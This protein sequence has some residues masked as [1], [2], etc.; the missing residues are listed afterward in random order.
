MSPSL[1]RR[2]I[3][4]FPP[5]PI[6]PPEIIGPGGIRAPNSGLDPNTKSFIAAGAAG[7]L[8]AGLNRFAKQPFGRTFA[9]ANTLFQGGAKAQDFFSRPTT[10]NYSSTFSPTGD[11]REIIR[12]SGFGGT[13]DSLFGVEPELDPDNP[14]TKNPWFAMGPTYTPN[15]KDKGFSGY[16]PVNWMSQLGQEFAWS[17][18][19]GKEKDQ[20]VNP[21]F[22]F[23]QVVNAADYLGDT[24]AGALTLPKRVYDIIPRVYNSPSSIPRKFGEFFT[25]QTE[26]QVGDKT[27]KIEG[28]GLIYEAL[29]TLTPSWNLGESIYGFANNML[30]ADRLIV[31]QNGQSVGVSQRE[32][33]LRY[34][35]LDFTPEKR[36]EAI[37]Q[38]KGT[39]KWPANI[40]EPNVVESGLAYVHSAA[41]NR[42]RTFHALPLGEQL[43]A[44]I[45]LPMGLES[46]TDLAVVKKALGNNYF[47]TFDFMQDLSN[48][49]KARRGEL[50]L[51]NTAVMTLTNNM[52]P[53]ARP[54][55][56][57]AAAS[58]GEIFEPVSWW[59]KARRKVGLLGLQ[60]KT[61]AHEWVRAANGAMHELFTFVTPENTPQIMRAIIDY[62]DAIAEDVLTPVQARARTYLNSIG[63]QAKPFDEATRKFLGLPVDAVEDF[64]HSTSTTAARKLILDL[65]AMGRNKAGE[66]L[67]LMEASKI[68]IV[69]AGVAPT[70]ESYEASARAQ[71]A[72]VKMVTEA[73]Q[74]SL[75]KLLGVEKP[76]LLQ[77]INDAMGFFASRFHFA[78]IG[79]GV[80]NLEQELFK[81]LGYS[82]E[83]LSTSGK[84]IMKFGRVIAGAAT[85]FDSDPK[86][87]RAF[88][89]GYEGTLK[90]GPDASFWQKISNHGIAFMS[91]T[92]AYAREKYIQSSL[93]KVMGGYLDGFS[94]FGGATKPVMPAGLNPALWQKLLEAKRGFYTADDIRSFMAAYEGGGESIWTNGRIRKFI[95]A[96]LINENLPDALHPMLLDIFKKTQNDIGPEKM[97]GLLNELLSEINSKANAILST[98]HKLDA[99]AAGNGVPVNLNQ[100]LETALPKVPADIIAGVTLGKV[101]AA[102]LHVLRN[103]NSPA[104]VAILE[105]MDRNGIDADQF[106]RIGL[107][108][109]EKISKYN[110]AK[111][112]NPKSKPQLLWESMF[113]PLDVP[114]SLVVEFRELYE[115]T[116][117][118]RDQALDMVRQI[119]DAHE[120]L[121]NDNI[122][123]PN[124]FV[125]FTKIFLVDLMQP[126]HPTISLAEFLITRTG[127]MS[128]LKGLGDDLS[129][130]PVSQLT[131]NNNMLLPYLTDISKKFGT[132]VGEFTSAHVGNLKLEG[133]ARQEVYRQMAE[134]TRDVNYQLVKVQEEI[135][136]S[137][138]ADIVS[139][140]TKGLA[141]Q[142]F[143]T[144]A[145]PVSAPRAV[146]S[147]ASAI[148]PF[149]PIPPT[150]A[151]LAFH[152]SKSANL[153][154]FSTNVLG[155]STR[156]TPY[157]HGFYFALNEKDA[158][159]RAK[160]FAI[161]VGLTYKSPLAIDSTAAN[162][163]EIL[164]GIFGYPDASFEEFVR[165]TDPDDFLQIMKAKGYD[166]V[167][168]YS[169]NTLK[170][171]VVL[172]PNQIHKSFDEARQIAGP[173]PAVVAAP[174]VAPAVASVP[175]PNPA[176]AVASTA[177]TLPPIGSLSDVI[178]EPDKTGMLLPIEQEAKQIAMASGMIRKLR[179]ELSDLWRVNDA[180]PNATPTESEAA[181]KLQQLMITQLGKM[182]AVAEYVADDFA[183]FH[184]FDYS[185]KFNFDRYAETLWGYPF[186]WLRTYS[187]YPRQLLM[188]PNNLNH[189]WQLHSRVKEYNE[190]RGMPQNMLNTLPVPVP[191]SLRDFFRTDAMEINF[192]GAISP[193]DRMLSGRVPDPYR[194]RTALGETYN[195]VFS[196]ISPA[197]IIPLALGTAY[198]F[199]AETAKDPEMMRQ[200]ETFF[201]SMG[202]WTG[203]LRDV[204]GAAEAMTGIKT[205]VSGG[206]SV[207]PAILGLEVAFGNLHPAIKV[208]LGAGA[209]AQF[210]SQYTLTKDGWVNTGTPYDRNKVSNVLYN[211]PAGS[212]VNGITVTEELLVDAA[213]VAQDPDKYSRMPEFERATQVWKWA[214][215]ETRKSSS[216]LAV[217]SM[218]GG[219]GMRGFGKAEKEQQVMVEEQTQLF[220]AMKNPAISDQ[221]IKSMWEDYSYKHPRSDIRTLFHRYGNQAFQVYAF[222][223][224]GRAM[225]FKKGEILNSAGIP[226]EL[227]SKFYDGLRTQGVGFMTST[228]EAAF[229]NGIIRAGMLLNFPDMASAEEI[230]AV[231]KLKPKYDAEL[232]MAYPKMDPLRDVLYGLPYEQ[233]DQ[234]LDEH[235]EL[236]SYLDAANSLMMD[237]KYRDTLAP[238]YLSMKEVEDLVVN[239]YMAKDPHRAV[240]LRAYLS[241]YKTFEDNKNLN[242]KKAYMEYFDLWDF[243]KGY[244]ALK[245]N[246]ESE[247]YNL[248]ADI[249]LPKLPTM[250]TG[251]DAYSDSMAVETMANTLNELALTGQKQ[252]DVKDA[253]LRA[254]GEGSQPRKSGKTSG[255]IMPRPMLDIPEN[256]W[257]KLKSEVTKDPNIINST[258]T[259]LDLGG[260][261]PKQIFDNYIKTGKV[262]FYEPSIQQRKEMDAFLA[263]GKG[264]GA[265]P[266]TATPAAP[267]SI[268]DLLIEKS[269]AAAG[270]V[271]TA[272]PRIG[273][274]PAANTVTTNRT[275]TGGTTGAANNSAVTGVI[276]E[277]RAERFPYDSQTTPG[278]YADLLED[279]RNK[280]DQTP[281][282]E[283][284]YVSQLGD[285]FTQNFLIPFAQQF[286]NDRKGLLANLEA[287]LTSRWMTF[288]RPDMWE[289]N[290]DDYVSRLG[291]KSLRGAIMEEAS[292]GT[293][294]ENLTWLRVLGTVRSMSDAEIDR[295]SQT[296]PQLKDL[297]IVKSELNNHQ[298]PTLNAMFDTIG[299]EVSFKED[300]SFGIVSTQIKEPKVDKPKR[301]GTGDVEDYISGQ[302][303]LYFGEDIEDIYDTYLEIGVTKGK[304]QAKLF[305]KQNP[306]LAQYQQFKE[307]MWKRWKDAQ[308]IYAASEKKA[309]VGPK[310]PTKIETGIKALQIMQKLDELGKGSHS[311][312]K[313]AARPYRMSDP[314][315]AMTA[316]FSALLGSGSKTSRKAPDDNSIYIN[317]I[318]SIRNINPN[319]AASFADLM[320]AN[321]QRRNVILQ[322]N[323]DLAKYI[324]QFTMQQLGEIEQSY[325]NG[326][327]MGN[328]QS[329]SSGSV[330]R[331]YPKRDNK[332]GL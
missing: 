111:G 257:N 286:V 323:P 37:A 148:D 79:P 61:M 202:G 120:F 291:G 152:G 265:A 180:V 160:P 170:E 94:I 92:E 127:G 283:F 154:K 259:R 324:T 232:E 235:P 322:S 189:Y 267:S 204:S 227:V 209:L 187:D 229:N 10:P 275:G 304:E 156:K 241:D 185:R 197:P 287:P 97:V 136:L 199:I 35:T 217:A 271:P 231:R 205:G 201:T 203:A 105:V 302:A 262:G 230:L 270:I 90:S 285:S 269:K 223:V 196:D 240:A 219:P 239:S 65:N 81:M 141:N 67:K 200:A 236:R 44:A 116:N 256:L 157:G 143:P 206:L 320:E 107:D 27:E 329:G 62:G 115:K 59:A 33:E 55:S 293:N 155:A 214:L 133:T 21:D 326:F 117:F 34:A 40:P 246:L 261:S 282:N 56:M 137:P 58:T 153:P 173:A 274:Q 272:V 140:I 104:A 258:V 178:V 328:G 108:V 114:E 66:L 298:S 218:L 290:L 129:K 171:V 30:G 226:D 237:P 255:G 215:L 221:D 24:V 195:N 167:E 71:S 174:I 238:Y 75:D 163:E 222:N 112:V 212:K 1:P 78:T 20:E 54:S 186:W 301:F 249:K 331:V 57:T 2:F 281:L 311:Q 247:I 11:D 264:G 138:T 169:K 181:S 224:L 119:P 12:P 132:K 28:H 72:I 177:I 288:E 110:I 279:W 278:T 210:Y 8:A 165:S 193:I 9:I 233:Q 88:V 121:L 6:T 313:V 64:L 198:M 13:P 36:I 145:V 277:N 332:T 77:P 15:F 102:A 318:T 4:P 100:L 3:N 95:D 63:V 168:V 190:G 292:R 253:I 46:L 176:S 26:K 23:G 299:V 80:R 183:N 327:Q 234:F 22:A 213:L 142:K 19:L 149:V 41:E 330:L 273:A 307:I 184:L 244:R 60:R 175:V 312:A 17:G 91:A 268:T 162:K 99:I 76:Y 126:D 87:L 49:T 306:K 7:L 325:Q 73:A 93:N 69:E 5:A 305:W 211:T 284:G 280:R 130:V 103:P 86:L 182:R 319:L 53:G 308:D 98:G 144:A 83:D 82:R 295:I 18:R 74:A 192:V 252:Q 166:A 294:V 251:Q 43:S 188:E 317:V 51:R 25:G 266:A 179:D 250:R 125:D 147:V 242:E 260:Y 123:N 101:D 89:K 118:Q 150:G 316:A 300:G 310:K 31:D 96:F 124:G 276:P 216:A 131:G 29:K 50:S 84:E 303:K 243:Y 309:A 297:A 16:N 263:Q 314:Y 207:D 172:E 134:L 85:R 254:R 39:G 161:E 159:V 296:N 42:Y 321:P 122:K 48:I 139:D 164:Q 70:K 191:V 225:I 315:S 135:Y 52:T 68:Q 194:D 106:R 45:G 228:E 47:P 32:K 14:W 208:V 38:W 151:Q 248:M 128:E 289:E 158:L 220:A 146:A 245:T 113:V 109:E